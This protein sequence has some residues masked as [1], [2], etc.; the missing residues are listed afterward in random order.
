M[1]R[2]IRWFRYSLFLILGIGLAACSLPAPVD[3]PTPTSGGVVTGEALVES[4]EVAILESFPVQVSAT[5]NGN[6][7]N[8][9]TTIRESQVEMDGSTFRITLLSEQPTGV[10][11]TEALVPFSETVSLD[12]LGLPAGDYTVVSGE[13]SATFNLAVDNF[14]PADTGSISGTVWHDICAV[15]GGE[16]GEPA[17]PSQGC[18]E[19]PEGG[20]AADGLLESGESGIGGIEVQLHESDCQG[21]VL[22]SVFT[23][24]DGAFSFEQLPDGMYCLSIDPLANPNS[25][26]LIPGGWTLPEGEVAGQIV[27]ISGGSAVTQVNFGWDYQFLPDPA[28]V[29]TLEPSVNP[30][31]TP[32]PTGTP[33]PN[34][35]GCTNRAEF[36]SESVA[37]DSIVPAGQTF[38]KTWTLKNTGTCRWNENYRV[39]FQ[40]GD[41]M[42]APDDFA[43]PGRVSPQEEVELS[44]VLTAPGSSGTYRGDFR[45]QDDLGNTFGLGTNANQPFWVRV[46]VEGQVVDLDLGSPDWTDEFDNANSWFLVNIQDTVRFSIENG[47]M[48]LRA[49]AAGKGDFWGVAN[50]PDLEDFYIEARFVNGPVCAGLD[51]YGLIVRAPE[52][53]VGYVF[54]IACNGQFRVYTWDGSYAQVQGW[55]ANLA[56]NSGPNATNRVG[57][58]AQGDD[59]T[60]VI[61][62]IQIATYTLDDFDEGQFGL[63]VGSVNT[64]NLDIFVEEISYWILD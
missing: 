61:N 33:E 28:D 35:A 16:G 51:R 52:P 60:L 29:P 42:G 57:V 64:A 50:R 13:A 21:T 17:V 15:A 38:T 3:D 5:L 56:I 22:A 37:D 36:V 4:I 40:G 48:R 25:G 1:R 45:L 30:T 54:N 47:R 49:I 24:P 41:R 2:Q 58:L 7:P 53:D 34:E 59:L 31:A 6:H 46:K 27:E 11:C 18:V 43:F 55:T 26:I 14:I 62:D 63:L 9:C 39:V 32:G 8:G 20:Y 19:L 12:V 23:T 10:A 44:V